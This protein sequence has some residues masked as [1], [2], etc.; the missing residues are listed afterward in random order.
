MLHLGEEGQIYPSRIH[1]QRRENQEEEQ[2]NVE[3]KVDLQ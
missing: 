1:G 2:T 3:V